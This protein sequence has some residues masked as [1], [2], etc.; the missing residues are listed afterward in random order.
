VLLPLSPPS[1]LPYKWGFL[2]E[3]YFQFRE[4]QGITGDY[5][6]TSVQRVF[7]VQ[8]DNWLLSLADFSAQ[9]AYE[10]LDPMI[11]APAI[12]KFCNPLSLISILGN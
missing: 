1:P 7:T 6:M 12:T 5:K 9:N 4:T 8:L 3:D 2:C 10:N 11:D